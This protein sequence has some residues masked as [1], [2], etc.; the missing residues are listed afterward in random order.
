MRKILILV[1]GGSGSRMGS[2][3]PKQ[4]LL[5]NGKPVLLHTLDQAHQA[6]PALEIVV[7]LP[8]TQLERWNA[9]C[10][11]HA[12]AVSHQ[13]VAGGATRYESVRNGLSAVSASITSPAQTVIG[14]HDG[15]RPYLPE[16]FLQRCFSEA[17]EKGTAIPC[18][19][20]T[21]SLRQQI[22]DRYS[23]VDRSRFFLMQT[24]QCFRADLGLRAYAGEEQSGFTDDASVLEQADIALH[25]VAGERWNIKITYPGDLAV[26][27]ALRAGK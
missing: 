26:A 25:F 5:L 10:R 18:L 22:G 21:D 13:T 20:V 17:S 12:C 2:D 4:F 14:I 9:L 7:V 1:A 8:A 15:V 19:P 23:A 6:D 27:A 11:E 3:V 24:P 16:E